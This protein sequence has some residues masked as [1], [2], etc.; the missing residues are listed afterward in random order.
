[1]LEFGATHFP[2]FF[3][4]VMAR[5]ADFAD[6]DPFTGLQL[7]SDDAY[8]SLGSMEAVD[9]TPAPPE[10]LTWRDYLPGFALSAALAALAIAANGWMPDS[11]PVGASVLAL[12]GAI[13]L[14][15]ALPLPVPVFARGCRW[16]VSNLIPVAIVALGAGLNLAILATDGLRFLGYIVAAVGVST[17]LALSLGRLLGV[18]KLAALLIGAGT[19]ICGS[20]AILAIAPVVD[21]E[22]DDIL[23][24]VGAINLV[25]LLAMF[26]CIGLGAIFP[27]PAIDFGILT[28]A[29]IHAVPTVAAA[30]FDHSPEAGQTATLVKLGR[31]AMLVPFVFVVSALW[32]RKHDSGKKATSKG[33]LK[34]VPW[35]VWGFA[36][37]ALIGSLGLIPQLVFADGPLSSSESTLSGAALLSSGGKFLLTVAMAAIGLQVGLKSMLRTG[38]RAVLL[39]VVVWIAVTG[40]IGVLLRFT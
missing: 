17:V 7:L 29:T 2:S 3:P 34:F 36:A 20:S 9:W 28:G 4:K 23:L 8:L 1:M 16:I 24:S 38:A 40:L 14:R 37:T 5:P 22:E 12:V 35:F 11:L 6:N 31:V 32:R 18:K 15:N 30:A 21:A 27:I 39:S 33:I 13:L 25:G 19:G 10:A 26:A